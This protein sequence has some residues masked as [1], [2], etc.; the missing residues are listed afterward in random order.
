MSDIF[1]Q[2]KTR[3]GGDGGPRSG[4][5]ALAASVILHAGAVVVFMA[6]SSPSPVNIVKPRGSDVIMFEFESPGDGGA[7]QEQQRA[8][9]EQQAQLEQEQLAKLEQ[10]RQAQLEQEQL[11]KLEQERQAQLEQEQLVKLEQERQ[12]QLEQEQLV[13]LEQERQAQLEQEQLAKLE[14]E[15]Q[16]KLEQ[17]RQAKLEQERQAKLEQ[18][19]QAKLEQERQAKLEQERQAKLEQERQAQLEQEQLVKLEQERQAKLEQERQAKLEQERQANLEKERQAKLE[20]ERQANLEKENQELDR[21]VDDAVATIAKKLQEQGGRSGSASG[22]E[23]DPAVA[24]YYRYIRDIIS[25]NWL[26][27][28]E[29]SAADLVATYNIV[30]QPGGQVSSSLLKSSGNSLYDLSVERALRS[31]VPFMP[32]PGVFN[33]RAITVQ[34]D[35]SLNELR[36]GA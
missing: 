22:D 24:A 26:A 12:A 4:F 27:P 19:R 10:E 29:V 31:S 1:R 25:R 5:I 32:L 28:A 3:N 7:S 36:R 11:A 8:Q 14:Q 34:L 21:G 16:A 6:L 18:E 13:K 17:E 23:V 15:R 2:Y 33:G 30:I 35:F 20:Q 9:R